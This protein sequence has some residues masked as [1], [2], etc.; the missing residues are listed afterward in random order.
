MWPLVCF[1]KG[2]V[3]CRRICGCLGKSHSVQICKF[4]YCPVSICGDYFKKVLTFNSGDQT[5][6]RT[7]AEHLQTVKI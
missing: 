5:V 1:Y 3:V 7:A 4:I 6:R 2:E